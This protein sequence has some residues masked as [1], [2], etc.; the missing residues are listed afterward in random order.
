MVQKNHIL[1]DR[2]GTYLAGLCMCGEVSK[3][4][5]DSDRKSDSGAGFLCKSNF[6]LVFLGGKKQRYT[7]L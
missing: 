6:G 1:I 7:T 3:T 4:P 5:N 2:S